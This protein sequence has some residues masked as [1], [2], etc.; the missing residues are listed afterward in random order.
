MESNREWLI[1]KDEKRKLSKQKEN[2]M[3]GETIWFGNSKFTQNA[4]SGRK[5][6]S[7]EPAFW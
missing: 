6:I 4:E 5:K 7:E 1:Y 3:Q 2:L